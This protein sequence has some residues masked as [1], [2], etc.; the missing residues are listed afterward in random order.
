MVICLSFYSWFYVVKFWQ[1]DP[2]NLPFKVLQY[3]RILSILSR[4][5]ESGSHFAK[6]LS[7][8]YTYDS[9]FGAIFTSFSI[10][11]YRGSFS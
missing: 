6:D 4:I 11:A 2:N 7:I 5:P 3:S 9:I 8:F 10:A 1:D